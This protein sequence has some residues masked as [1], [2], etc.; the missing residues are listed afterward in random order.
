MAGFV[1]TSIY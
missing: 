1:E